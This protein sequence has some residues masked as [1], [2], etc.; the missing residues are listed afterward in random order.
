MR[1]DEMNAQEQCDYLVLTAL[2][3]ELSSLEA[4]LEMSG[5]TKVRR[6][7]H[8]E[9]VTAFEWHLSHALGTLVVDTASVHGMGNEASG[10]VTR[11]L[12]QSIRPKFIGFVGIA[13]AAYPMDFGQVLVAERIWHY[14]PAKVSGT[15]TQ[16]R[17][18]TFEVDHLIL[19]RLRYLDLSLL[20]SMFSE[21]APWKP[22][23]LGTIA[24]GEKVVA[25]VE[26][27]D[28]LGAS[29]RNVIGFEMEGH[30]FAYHAARTLGARWF[31]I[32]AVSDRADAVKD[33]RHRK[34]ACDRAAQFLV[35]FMH[36]SDLLIPTL[37]PPSPS[38]PT[39]PRGPEP[40][41]VSTRQVSEDQNLIKQLSLSLVGT[42]PADLLT[43]AKTVARPNDVDWALRI[44]EAN[45]KTGDVAGCAE[46]ADR[47]AT[48]AFQAG[49]EDVWAVAERL[50]C[51][52][53]WKLGGAAEEYKALKR[54]LPTITDRA[55]RA[56]WIDLLAA[57]KRFDGT[58]DSAEVG[59]G[60]YHQALEEKQE[61]GD[62]LG[63][64]MSMF[65]IALFHIERGQIAQG[66]VYFERLRALADANKYDGNTASS[67]LAELGIAWC[68]LL[69]GN[70]LS[71]RLARDLVRDLQGIWHSNQNSPWSSTIPAVARA[72]LYLFDVRSSDQ[73]AQAAATIPE[74]TREQWAD[75]IVAQARAVAGMPVDDLV[76]GLHDTDQ[77]LLAPT[78]YRSL[79]ELPKRK[80]TAPERASPLEPLP[81]VE[82]VFW[83][84]TAWLAE[85]AHD[86]L[87]R[88]QLLEAI[89]NLYGAIVCGMDPSLG[90]FKPG[91]VGQTATLMSEWARRR[92]DHRL[93]FEIRQVTAILTEATPARNR[94][95]H[96]APGQAPDA[97]RQTVIEASELIIGHTPLLHAARWTENTEGAELI[98]ADERVRLEPFVTRGSDGKLSVHT[99]PGNSAS[100]RA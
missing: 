37:A 86:L 55:E 66:R 12:L 43:I 59:M 18:V 21:G 36:D 40:A 94:L 91:T 75:V 63:Q 9:A 52:A 13:G 62:L 5:A 95:I 39:A 28:E 49:R 29:A 88:V 67:A 19:D 84:L 25:N 38:V 1:L 27:R 60:W 54:G 61:T 89:S 74:T 98:I 47:A 45:W 58:Q 79:L 100:R 46:A 20:N 30:A 15:G 96:A 99:A 78:R 16:R 35:A 24:S 48:L 90:P 65:Q 97:A 92:P 69:G 77:P 87:G 57:I 72:L 11:G 31:M 50:R 73:P 4:A 64:A 32:R 51:W 70:A 68:Y 23:L 3:D 42:R 34:L 82:T 2:D 10:E 22:A 56:R 44:A 85:A 80:D 41:P 53:N 76:G 83:P 17:G 71:H 93:A 81:E 6:V 14:E 8:G 26:L 33:D 7:R